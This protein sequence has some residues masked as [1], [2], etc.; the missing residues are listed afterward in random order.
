MLLYRAAEPAGLVALQRQRWD[1]VLDWARDTLGARFV[2]VEGV[3][4]VTQPPDAIAAAA[5]AIPNGA[6]IENAW[7][8]GALNVVTTL[9]GSGLLALAL[10]AGRITVDEAW[11]AAHADEDWNMEFWGRDE[12]ALQRRAYRFAEISA[13]ATVLSLLR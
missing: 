2:T 8:L 6:A 11:A 3:M 9:T 4:F 5:A 10:A 7:R 1:P 12:L 13:A